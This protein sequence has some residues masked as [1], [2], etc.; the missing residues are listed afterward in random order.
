MILRPTLVARLK[1]YREVIGAG[2]V[3]A[4]GLWVAAQGGVILVPLGLVIAALGATLALNAWRRARFAQGTSAPGIVELDEGQIGYL[5]PDLGG[6]LSLN[7][8]VE[9]RL[10][11]I[12]GK[13]MWRLKQSDGQA[14]LIPVDAAGAER[15]FD[16]FVNLAGMDSAALIAALGAPPAENLS[17]AR[18]VWRR[19]PAVTKAS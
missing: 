12:R 3:A 18:V 16:A 2:V 5:A 8:L 1:P 15:L 10:L 9:I 17:E 14:M 19:P 13:R 6:Y 7:E 4:L 11:T